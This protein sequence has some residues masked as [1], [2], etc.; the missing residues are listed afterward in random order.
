MANSQAS[1]G[2]SH[3]VLHRYLMVAEVFCAYPEPRGGWQ[4][5]SRIILEGGVQVL[6]KPSSGTNAPGA[7]APDEGVKREVAASLIASILGWSHLIAPT[8]RRTMAPAAGG[9]ECEVSLQLI[10][11]EPLTFTPDPSGFELFDVWRAAVFDAV[12]RNADRNRNNWLGMGPDMSGKT[13][14]KLIDHGHC[15]GG[16]PLN[17]SFVTYVG[18]AGAPATIRDEIRIGLN[19]W[20]DAQMYDLLQDEHETIRARLRRVAAGEPIDALH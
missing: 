9:P 17:S 19:G 2:S 12:V 13:H 15:F 11:P 7:A 14:L 3:E 8:V 18:G 6:Q 10:W 4:N 5:K 20:L 16:G 1:Q